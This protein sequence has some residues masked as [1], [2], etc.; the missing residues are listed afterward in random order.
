VN[1][2]AETEARRR[3]LGPASASYAPFVPAIV[4][5]GGFFLVPLGIIVIYGFW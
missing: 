3:R 5:L 2:A 1:T 4:L